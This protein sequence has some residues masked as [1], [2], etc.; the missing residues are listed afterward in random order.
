MAR[1]K[2]VVARVLRSPQLQQSLGSLTIGLRDG[3]LPMIG[4][5]LGIHM[6]NGGFM[7]GTSMPLGGGNAV[8]AFVEG[9]KDT[10]ERQKR[11]RKGDNEDAEMS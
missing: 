10:V 3:G 1:K 7:R 6:E 8:K 5:S 2:A 9:V 11:K 4:E